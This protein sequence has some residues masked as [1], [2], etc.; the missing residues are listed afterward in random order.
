[1]FTQSDVVYAYTRKQAIEDG[2]QVLLDSQLTKEAGYKYPVYLTH[3]VW[4]LVEM[5][6]NNK[7]CHNDLQGV[8]WDILWMSIRNHTRKFDNSTY[9]FV[10]IITGTGRKRN[11]SLIVQCGPTDIDDPAPVIT[12]MLPEDM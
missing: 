3:S 4:T 6:V 10:V 7:K 5:A 8:L 11:H 1:M 9:E 12:I 2:F